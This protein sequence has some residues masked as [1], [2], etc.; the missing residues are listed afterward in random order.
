MTAAEIDRAIEGVLRSAWRPSDGLGDCDQA[1]D[2]QWYTMIF[3][4][5]TLQQTLDT[6]RILLNK[7]SAP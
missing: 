5:D 1:V 3:G 4:R 6:V 2:G 7:V